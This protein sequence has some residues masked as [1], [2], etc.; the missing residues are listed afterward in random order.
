M[1]IPDSSLLCDVFSYRRMSYVSDLGAAVDSC[2]IIVLALISLFVPSIVML[3]VIYE[4][5]N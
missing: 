5:G 1:T 4:L 2:S 3:G